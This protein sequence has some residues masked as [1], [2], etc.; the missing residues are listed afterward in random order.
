[1]YEGGLMEWFDRFVKEYLEAK[2]RLTTTSSSNPLLGL[3]RKTR[4]AINIEEASMKAAFDMLERR[5]EEPMKVAITGQFSSGKSTFLNALLS[6]D[7]LPT[8]ITPVTSKVNYIRYGNSFQLQVHYNDGREAFYG[9]ENIASFIDQRKSMEDVKYLT[10][11]AP[12]PLL[13]EVVFVDT[14]G[15]NSQAQSDTKTTQNVLKEVDGIIWLTLIDNAGKQSEVEVLRTYMDA[16]DSKSLC[17]LNQKDK[18][19]DEDV[20]KTV[21]YINDSLGGFFA[22]VVAI[23]A[24][25]ALK[26][27]SQSRQNRLEEALQIL[28]EDIQ[29]KS[30]SDGVL[31]DDSFNEAIE[32]YTKTCQEILAEPDDANVALLEES[33]I[34][35]VLEFIQEQ[36]RPKANQSKAYAIEK[37]LD[38]LKEISIK[39]HQE[40][41]RVYEELEEILNSFEKEAQKTFEEL[42]TRFGRELHEAYNKIQNIID[43]IASQILNHVQTQTRTRYKAQKKGII[44]KKVYYEPIAYEVA[45]INAD[46]VYKILFY[47]EDVIGKMFKKYVRYLRTIQDGVN[48]ENSLIYQKLESKVTSWQHKYEIFSP[49]EEL[50]SKEEF[51]RLRRFASKAYETFLKP[52]NDEIR[53]SY[54][55]ISSQFN[56]LSSAVSFNYQNA[57]E[58]SVGFLERK[59]SESIG[60]YEENPELFPL[61]QPKLDEIKNR[62]KTSFHLYELENM[63]YTNRTFLHKNYERLVNQFSKIMSKHREFLEEKKAYHKECIKR[64]KS[65][66]K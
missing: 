43:T 66:K 34:H 7:I 58:V 5:A 24:K 25:Q 32:T 41:L 9:V 54:A 47:D 26:A 23:S 45:K 64:I 15:L 38:W 56:H 14:P 31:S 28:L 12:L 8:G 22:K 19:S 18:F 63:M 59:I 27:R 1:M 61:Y 46:E 11:Y 37:G 30:Q 51:A 52:F 39:Q 36:I 62:L 2:K 55:Q 21:K 44:G 29:K 42:K 13:K 4:Q 40:L 53:G 48:Q 6:K 50:Y 49:K 33:N 57:T 3:I 65:V 10:L 35:S 20:Q 60:L 16:Y 17:V